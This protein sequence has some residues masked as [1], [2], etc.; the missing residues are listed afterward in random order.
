MHALAEAAGVFFLKRLEIIVFHTQY[1]TRIN[2]AHVQTR[3]LSKRY[4]SVCSPVDFVNFEFVI[5]PTYH[6]LAE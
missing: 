6:V 3:H 1:V 4:I 2:A 5:F